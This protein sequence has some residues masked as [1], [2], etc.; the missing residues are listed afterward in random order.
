MRAHEA[1][2]LHAEGYGEPR[3]GCALPARR[4]RAAS[5]RCGRRPS[6]AARDG[7][8][9]VGG[10]VRPRPR[11]R[12]RHRR[13]TSSTRPTSAL[14]H[15][16]SATPTPRCSPT[17][18]AAPTSTTPA[19]PSSAPRWPAGS[20]TTTCAS[21]SAPAVSSPSPCGP[22]CRARGSACT[23]TTSR[24]AELRAG[25]ALRRGPDHRRLLRRDRA[26]RPTSRA[27]SAPSRGSWSASPSASRRTPTSSS[28]RRTRTRSSASR[29]SGGDAAEAVRRILAAAPHL[30]LIGLHSHIGSQIFDTSGF[31]V[32][33]PAGARPA[34]G[35]R[36]GA[37][38]RA[39]RAGP[40]RRLRDRLHDGA[41]PAAA[42]APRGRDGR[43]RRP[44]VP[45]RAASPCPAS[46]SSPVARSPGRAPS[47]CTRSA[48]SRWSTSTVAPPGPTSRV[49]GG[50][51]DNIRT[52]LYE[53]NFSCT[54]AGRTSAAPPRLSRVVGKHCESGDIVVM[55]EFLPADVAPGD[56]LAVPGTGAYCR[57][58]VQ[59]VQ[60]HPAPAGGRRRGRA[61]PR[62]GAP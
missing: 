10:V 43:D 53:A 31:E 21:T 54:L 45:G 1:G 17:S 47:R 51:S 60:P 58:L 26:A 2:A 49:D 4:Q 57:S 44:R 29:L 9:T 33:R 13:P 24:S 15:A 48:P 32:S 7:A 27:G 61:G 39:A 16:T 59:P 42:E 50:M 52:A 37:R 36:Q 28:R 8:L 56:L 14:G 11:T 3:R 40:R 30:E 6:G 35:R 34:R 23:A 25:A 38:R 5:R 19:R 22:V 18:A 20:A 62:P 46:R 55:D 41:R 12:V